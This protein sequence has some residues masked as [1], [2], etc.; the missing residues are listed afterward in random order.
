MK[1][2]YLISDTHFGHWFANFLWNRP[3]KNLKVMNEKIIENWN[4][5]VDEDD[6]ILIVG[7]FFAGSQAFSNYLLSNLKGKKILIKGNHDFKYRYRK[8]FKDQNMKIFNRLSFHFKD[9]EILLTHKATKDLPDNTINIHGH[10]HRFHIPLGFEKSKYFNVNVDLNDYRPVLLEDII[11]KK[12]KER[13]EMDCKLSLLEQIQYSKKN[14]AY[15]L[16]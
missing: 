2:I 16:S 10:Y 13:L 12:F 6:Y 15:S 8:L 7:D 11:E 1:N 9:K 3:F 4:K 5:T 14:L